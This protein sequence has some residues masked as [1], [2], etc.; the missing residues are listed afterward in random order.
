MTVLLVALPAYLGC[1]VEV[2]KLETVV[3]G[4]YRDVPW[5]DVAV[6]DAET[7]VEVVDSLCRV[8]VSVWGNN[9]EGE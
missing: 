7:E 9:R 8:L 5:V 2:E 4:V 3:F 1:T 6:V